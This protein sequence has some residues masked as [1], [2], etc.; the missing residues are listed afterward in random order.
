MHANRRAVER[1]YLYYAP[2][3]MGVVGLVMATHAFAHWRDLG[4]LLLGVGLALPV[5]LAPL[6]PLSG[7]RSV[8]L[9]RRYSLKSALYITLFSCLENYFGTPI[10]FRCFGLEYHFPVTIE[11]NGSPLFLSFMTVAYFSTY[12]ALMQLGLRFLGSLLAESFSPFWRRCLWFL[13][14]AGMAY[15]LALLETL[16]MA[17]KHLQG[18]FSYGDKQRMMFVGSLC[19]GTMLFV[20]ILLYVGIDDEKPHRGGRVDEA[21]AGRETPLG[22]VIWRALGANTLVLCAFEVY[23]HF[24]SS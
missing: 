6:W 17:N 5:W 8:A 12:F 7:E 16:F 23:A 14:A 2:L 19:Y 13:S 4:H 18:Y 21:S 3:W 1:Y 9:L 22:D 15:V 10:F 24:L 20:G 11:L